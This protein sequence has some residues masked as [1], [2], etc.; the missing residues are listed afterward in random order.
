MPITEDLVEFIAREVNGTTLV[1][2]DGATID[3]AKWQR[4]TMRE[5]IREFWPQ[6]AG[7]KPAETAFA[8]AQ[9]LQA[10]L[11]AAMSSLETAASQTN[12]IGPE[13]LPELKRI[14]PIPAG[15]YHTI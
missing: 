13:R 11:H 15:H 5:A 1:E 14:H 7:A 12:T 3:L 10:R 6:E 9:V 8:S 2:F 4:L